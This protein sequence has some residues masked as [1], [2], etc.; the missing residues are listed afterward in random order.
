[1]HVRDLPT[2]LQPNDHLVL[3]NTQVLPARLI[4]RRRQTGG[5]WQGL[6]LRADENGL[7]ELLAK[8]RGK[9]AVGEKIVL[10]DRNGAESFELELA[11]RLDNGGWVMSP[12]DDRPFPALLDEVGRTPL[13]P[14]IRKGE[15]VPEDLQNY[16]T[17]FA[18]QPGAVAAPTAGLH[19]TEKLLAELAEK[20]IGRSFV[21]LH[22]GVGTFRPLA[23]DQ[24]EDHS[25][26]SEW[27]EVSQAAVDEVH[28]AK[29]QQGR[30]IA[31][32]TTSVR[33]LET[34]A[35]SG[36]LT[37]YQGETDLFIRP[38]FEFHAVDGLLTNF[39]LP[40]STLLVLVRTFGGDALIQQAYQEAIKEEYR[41]YSYG[42][43][44]LII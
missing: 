2:L 37:P 42:D 10:I 16:Q 3:N 32:G 18:S 44:M 31:I 11:A 20:G 24:L 9:V 4:G 29:Q 27:I 41:F 34:A 38:S 5:R 39:H 21:T 15:M 30:V 40:K 28:A 1:M 12:A 8:T 26:H 23:V 14:Y 43:A 7:W 33:S 36:E 17:V 22:V 25:M 35:Q 13:P 6:F 19:F